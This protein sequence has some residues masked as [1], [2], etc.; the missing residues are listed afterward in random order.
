MMKPTAVRRRTVIAAALQLL[1]VLWI[2]TAVAAALPQERAALADECFAA[3]PTVAVFTGRF[4]T[5]APVY[6]L[7]PVTITAGRGAAT[8]ETAAAKRAPVEARSTR[9]RNARPPS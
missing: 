9:S 4:E 7:P 2:A 5:G 3:A 8:P 1:G 6:R